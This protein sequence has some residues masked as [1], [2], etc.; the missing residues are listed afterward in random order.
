VS[1]SLTDLEG[2]EDMPYGSEDDG[3]F[4][5]RPLDEIC[6]EDNEADDK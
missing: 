1:T 6:R 3:S 5:S 2:S 4:L